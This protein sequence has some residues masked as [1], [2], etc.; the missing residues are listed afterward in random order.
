MLVDVHPKNTRRFSF[1]STSLLITR[2][3]VLNGIS[4]IN[5][6]FNNPIIDAKPLFIYSAMVSSEILSP[7]IWRKQHFW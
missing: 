5:H 1:E 3:L 6:L 2:E 7:Q 4:I